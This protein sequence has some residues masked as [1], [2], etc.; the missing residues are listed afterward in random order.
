MLMN[1]LFDTPLTLHTVTITTAISLST[2]MPQGSL[3][4]DNTWC[5]VNNV[6]SI[7]TAC[8][9]CIRIHYRSELRELSFYGSF[10]ATRVCAYGDL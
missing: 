10:H 5:S 7:G 8:L 2:Y 3:L 4:L 9:T 6:W 1:I